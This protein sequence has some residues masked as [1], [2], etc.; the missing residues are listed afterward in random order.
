[1]YSKHNSVKLIY[2]GVDQS[3]DRSMR[4]LGRRAGHSG[5]RKRRETRIND[6]SYISKGI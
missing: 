6:Q 1:M 4:A 5:Q 2:Q 3:L